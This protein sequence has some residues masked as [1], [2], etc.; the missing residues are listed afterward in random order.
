M[1]NL[2]Q[3][4]PVEQTTESGRRV[5]S[6]ASGNYLLEV[7][8]LQ[9]QLIREADFASPH[10]INTYVRYGQSRGNRIGEIKEEENQQHPLRLYNM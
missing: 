2:F 5:I 6:Q 1:L 3:G 7:L 4:A 10:Q 9:D 8:Q